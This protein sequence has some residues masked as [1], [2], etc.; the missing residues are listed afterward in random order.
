MFPQHHRRVA[1]SGL[2]PL[3]PDSPQTHNKTPTQ[4]T[5]VE[6]DAIKIGSCPQDREIQTSVML[7]SAEYNLIK[8]AYAQDMRIRDRARATR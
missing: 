7:V 5:V 3:N 6:A 2:F 4:S 8:Q 1:G